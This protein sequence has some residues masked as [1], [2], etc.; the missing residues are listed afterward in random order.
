MAEATERHSALL[1]ALE[2]Q[3][4]DEGDPDGR[5]ERLHDTVTVTPVWLYALDERHWERIL[6]LRTETPELPLYDTPPAWTRG[7]PHDIAD[8]PWYLSAALLALYDQL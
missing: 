7:E 2:E 5:Y 4:D 8:D 1:A 3:I 6:A